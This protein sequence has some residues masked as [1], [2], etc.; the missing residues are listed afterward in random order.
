MVT[1]E[2]KNTP[3]PVERT[4]IPNLYVLERK[5]NIDERGFFREV[6]EK[7]DLEEKL[8][9]SLSFVQWNH[10]H[11][12]GL[13]KKDL[14]ANQ[15]KIVYVA[16]GTAS[17]IVEA[18]EQGTRRFNNKECFVLGEENKRALFLPRGVDGSLVTLGSQAADI[19]CALTREDNNYVPFASLSTDI[20]GLKV[21]KYHQRI[22]NGGCL[23]QIFRESDLINILP[24]QTGLVQWNHSRSFPGVIRGFHAEP[25]NKLVY[26][27]RGK[28]LSVVADL[29]P[30]SATFGKVVAQTL[31]DGSPQALYISRGLANSFCALEE[32][33]YNYF[34]TA[35]FEGKPTPSVVW[36]DPLLTRQ[37]GGWRVEN[38][39]VSNTDRKHPTLWEKFHDTVDF[40]QY[41]WLSS[42]GG[43]R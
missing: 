10:Y 33:D 39:L 43:T 35:Y 17:I 41:P 21:L 28:V 31:G 29:R 23:Q 5:T 37:F 6:V 34:V 13:L 16:C 19:F 18:S 4:S 2:T 30:E 26:V 32:S 1:V 38:P 7:R 12:K 20:E 9:R 24:G 15:D 27:P 22:T 25:W 42:R 8:G 14:S 11:T 3:S 36:N 40:S